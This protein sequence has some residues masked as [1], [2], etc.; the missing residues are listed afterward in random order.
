M[1]LHG[2]MGK[3]LRINLH[4]MKTKVEEVPEELLRKYIGGSGYAARILY[5]ELDAEVDPL[6]EAN[7]LVFATSPLTQNNIAGGGSVMLCFKSPLTGGWGESRCGGNFGPD[8]RKA[9]YDFVIIEGKSYSIDGL[10][11]KGGTICN[12][13]PQKSLDLVRET[14]STS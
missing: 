11:D 8:L 2:Y 1:S 4:E 14:T 10:L 9:G 13:L 12:Y 7:I 3:Q 6:S 5:D